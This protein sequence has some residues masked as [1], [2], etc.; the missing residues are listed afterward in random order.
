MRKLRGPCAEILG[1]L[2]FLNE[3]LPEDRDPV[4][5]WTL[6]SCVLVF[7]LADD[8]HLFLFYMMIVYCV[9]KKIVER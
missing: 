2:R 3:Y 6:I 4:H 9:R 7:T 5:A 8:Y 1:K